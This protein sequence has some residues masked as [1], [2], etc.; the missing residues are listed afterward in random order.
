MDEKNGKVIMGGIITLPIHFF[1]LKKGIDGHLK[2]YLF[3]DLVS[4]RANA[5]NA[6][7]CNQ[8]MNYCDFDEDV[9]RE[10]IFF[11]HDLVEP[12][13]SSHNPD[14]IRPD[15]EMT[16]PATAETCDT[17]CWMNQMEIDAITRWSV[18]YTKILISNKM[19]AA[20]PAKGTWPNWADV[21]W[22]G[23]IIKCCTD[24]TAETRDYQPKNPPLY[25]SARSPK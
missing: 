10:G 16:E 6:N 8:Y 18:A 14:L 3:P 23:E 13:R 1:D 5:L 4:C 15:V 19:N 25:L 22:N 24:E 12:I 7:P 17:S 21:Q 2:E 9:Y 20:W 11:N